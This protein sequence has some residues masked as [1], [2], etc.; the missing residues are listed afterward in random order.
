MGKT[1]AGQ[2]TKAAA[3]ILLGATLVGI[4]EALALAARSG[5][6]GAQARDALLGGDADSRALADQGLRMVEARFA[7]GVPIARMAEDLREIVDDADAR[8]LDLPGLG[9][10]AFVYR[11]ALERGLAGL[12]QS[13][14]VKL[15]Q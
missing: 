10:S 1:G 3:R 11:R 2:A 15:Y 9:A 14:I 4:A 6:D 5:V 8:D 7:N 13:A 12:D